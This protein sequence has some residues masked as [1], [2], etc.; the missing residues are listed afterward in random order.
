MPLFPTVVTGV[1]ITSIGISI[2]QVVIDWAAG[3]KGNPDYGSP[4]YIGTS[5]LVLVFILLVTRFA[6]GF[7]CNISVLLGIFIWVCHCF[8]DGESQFCRARQCGVVCSH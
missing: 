2:M 5:L 3:G 4:I 6:K 1:V 7:L 8:Y